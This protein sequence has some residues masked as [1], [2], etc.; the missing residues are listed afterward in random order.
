M[1]NW[2]KVATFRRFVL[3]T[4]TQM[5]ILYIPTSDECLKRA[6]KV[7]MGKKEDFQKNLNFSIFHLKFKEKIS[8]SDEC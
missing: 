6:E 4:P 5:H 1:K 3:A 2:F 8:T 7:L